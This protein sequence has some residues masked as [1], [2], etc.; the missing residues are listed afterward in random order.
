MVRRHDAARRG[1]V[2]RAGAEPERDRGWRHHRV[3][4]GARGRRRHRPRPEEGGSRGRSAA[5]GGRP[6]RGAVH[7]VAGGRAV[8]VPRVPDACADRPGQ[9][10]A[11]GGHPAGRLLRPAT[12]G[13]AVRRARPGGDG[14]DPSDAA[15]RGR[16]G[17]RR[18]GAACRSHGRARP[19]CRAGRL[20]RPGASCAAGAA[21]RPLRACRAHRRRTLSL[22]AYHAIGGI[23]GAIAARADELFL[24]LDDADRQQVR[25]LFERL[26]VVDT[27]GE[28]TRRRAS[29]D[30]LDASTEVVDHGLLRGCSRSTYT[31]RPGCRPSRW[32]TRPWSGSGRGCGSGSRTT[33]AS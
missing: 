21:V 9:Q 19:G 3:G 33:G 18:A 5:A 29:R 32:P 2:Q 4:A 20:A 26:V 1:A 16:G 30:E 11:R 27:D 22:A 12:G 28:P 31:R 7:T 14:D 15:G 24:S 10:A 23:D 17:R 8:G 13:A 25:E 6:V